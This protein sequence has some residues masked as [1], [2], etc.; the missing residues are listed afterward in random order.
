MP[1]WPDLPEW[2][3]WV[4]AIAFLMWV[5]GLMILWRLWLICLV[6]VDCR[7]LMTRLVTE[8]DQARQRA[9]THRRPPPGPPSELARSG[10]AGG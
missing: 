4:I 7:R 5:T 2:S 9:G 1:E 3:R 6:L 8:I 10:R